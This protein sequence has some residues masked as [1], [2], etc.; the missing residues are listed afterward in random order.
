L[1]LTGFLLIYGINHI[2]NF[3]GVKKMDKTTEQAIYEML[4]ES[5]GTHFLDSG[6]ATG[7]HWQRNQIKTIQD[8][9]NQ[10]LVIYDPTFDEITLNIF[11]FLNEHLEYEE[12]QTEN[13]GVFNS[14]NCDSCLSQVIQFVYAGDF[15]EDNII[16]LSIHNG[17][18]VRGGYTDYKIFS[19]DYESLLCMISPEQWDH[20]RDEYEDKP[21]PDQEYLLIGGSD[22]P[23][24]FNGNT[25]EES[26]IK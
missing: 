22:S 25:W 1:T 6:G 13:I 15:Y 7:R 8:F 23:S 5:T 17:A 20:L 16:A 21:Q 2:F 24:I 11:P 9:K 12:E 18:D 4:T 26:K 10:E 14:Y 19:G 3:I